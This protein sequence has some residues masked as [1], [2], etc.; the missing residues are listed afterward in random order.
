MDRIAALR[1][2]LAVGEEGSLPRAARRLGV[3]TSLISRHVAQLEDSLRTGLMH[4]G[5]R[6]LELTATGRRVHDFA[7]RILSEIDAEDAALRQLYQNG[8]PARAKS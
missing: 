1:S 4:S 7:R 2:F 5:R 8:R 6:G 3:S